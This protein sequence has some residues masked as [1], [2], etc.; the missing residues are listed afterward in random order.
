MIGP[1]SKKSVTENGETIA[2]PFLV[3]RYRAAGVVN[4]YMRTKLFGVGGTPI[5]EDGMKI[6]YVTE[7]S[8]QVVGA[9]EFFAVYRT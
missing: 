1:S 9:N 7:R 6:Q 5:D 3:S 2:K 4:R 8:L